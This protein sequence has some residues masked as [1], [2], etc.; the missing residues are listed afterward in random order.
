MDHA[1]FTDGP[2]GLEPT[3]MDLRQDKQAIDWLRENVDGSPVVLEAVTP[4]YRWG[5]RISVYTGLPTVIGWDWHQTQQRPDMQPLIDR[6]KNDVQQ[7]L[8][9]TRTFAS[10]RPLLDRYNVRFIYIGP[11]ERAYYSE[12][13][14]AKFDEGVEN[15]MLEL[16][17]D[18]NGVKIY[19]YTAG[20]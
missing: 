13:A 5:S 18:Q 17:Y 16:V 4:L 3:Q 19:E 1:T 7:M 11:L 9:E 10:I 20:G 8:G 15:G 12:S 2:D 14:L 6:R